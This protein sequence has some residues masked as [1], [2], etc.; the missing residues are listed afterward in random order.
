MGAPPMGGM[1]MAAPGTTPGYTPPQP[2]QLATPP[3]PGNFGPPMAAPGM[4]TPPG[5]PGQYPG[6][7]P[8]AP[9]A[10]PA[11]PMRQ[12]MTQ[13]DPSNAGADALPAAM[14]NIVNALKAVQ[15]GLG[16]C[17]SK[18]EILELRNLLIGMAQTQN[19]LLV[20]LMDLCEPH[21][22][23][24]KDQQAQKVDVELRSGEPEK[25]FES[26]NQQGKG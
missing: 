15:A 1:P 18:A 2:G 12:P 23:L 14:G 25:Y 11:A 3:G 6:M 19:A 9:P 20:L 5:M 10:Q 8:G 7:P 4:A 13:S 24:S 21:L 22:G 26:L 17:A 16:Q